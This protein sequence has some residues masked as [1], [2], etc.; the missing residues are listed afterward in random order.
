MNRIFSKLKGYR[1]F[2]QAKSGWGGDETLKRL[3][4]TIS[5]GLLAIII[6]AAAFS[7]LAFMQIASTALLLAGASC[8][9]GG[10]LGFLFGIPRTNQVEVEEVHVETADPGK[11][12]V[13]RLYKPNTNLEQISDWLTKILVGVG[14]TQIHEITQWFR[15]LL[16]FFT[17]FLGN[18][19]AFVASIIIYFSVCGF[20]LGFLW[21]RLYMAGAIMKA[22]ADV[23]KEQIVKEVQNKVD[24]K[25]QYDAKAL[26]IVNQILNADAGAVN[27]SQEALNTIV[28]NASPVVKVTIFDHAQRFRQERWS[29]GSFDKLSRVVPIFRALIACDV[30]NKYHRNHGQLGYALKDKTNPD[31]PDAE[32]EFT[33]AIEIRDRTGKQGKWLLYE[34]NRAYCR[35][36]IN[37]LQQKEVFPIAAI[38]QD[39]Q[40]A[41]QAKAIKEIIVNEALFMDWLRA[42]NYKL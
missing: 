25:E 21:S 17:P 23:L 40:K 11:Q 34:F 9:S 37:E 4:N 10:F 8:I 22:E 35:I 24:E 13:N 16:N 12:S 5:L 42:T 7:K 32:T 27:I 6:F 30:E 19:P 33:K 41:S 29:D 15:R 18:N 1:L 3:I 39:L 28:S 14:L 31:Y 36:K 2:G 20:I 38:Y 26:S